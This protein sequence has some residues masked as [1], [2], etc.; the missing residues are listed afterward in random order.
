MRSL[1]WFIFRLDKESSFR[2]R[3]EE[4]L[5]RVERCLH[6]KESLI[7]VISK[8]RKELDERCKDLE[9]QLK[10]LQDDIDMQKANVEK[11]IIRRVDAENKL[12]TLKEETNFNAQIHVKVSQTPYLTISLWESICRK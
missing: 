5:K 4:E 10:C 1:Y 12:Q 8:E 9:E 3:A 2:S 6:K 11:E 7:I